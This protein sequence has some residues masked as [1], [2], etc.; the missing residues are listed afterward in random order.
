MMN[1]AWAVAVLAVVGTLVGAAVAAGNVWAS[2]G[3]LAPSAEPYEKE[4]IWPE[5]K[6]PDMQ[7]VSAMSPLP[8]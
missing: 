5:G 6:M 4:Y 1:R 7:P 2:F 8:E 3:P